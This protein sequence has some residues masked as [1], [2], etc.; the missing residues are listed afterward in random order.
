M[1]VASLSAVYIPHF[2]LPKHSIFMRP[3]L[4]IIG[5]MRSTSCFEMVSNSIVKDALVGSMVFLALVI[6]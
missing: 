1:Q 6:E 3:K 2:V 5:R 4:T